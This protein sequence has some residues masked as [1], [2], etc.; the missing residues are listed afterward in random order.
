MLEFIIILYVTN[1]VC[2]NIL[3][4]DVELELHRMSFFILT[5]VL[6][7]ILTII[8]T[9]IARHVVMH[10]SFLSASDYPLP[11]DNH[12]TQMCLDYKQW[13]VKKGKMAY[14][15][16][17]YHAN[18]VVCSSKGKRGKHPLTHRGYSSWTLSSR[19]TRCPSSGRINS[20]LSGQ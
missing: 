17:I 14:I 7:L 4:V 11:F 10:Y 5:T 6:G 9:M 2:V 13:G 19:L 1:S 15:L 16:P 12:H 8:N 18:G 20:L 3:L